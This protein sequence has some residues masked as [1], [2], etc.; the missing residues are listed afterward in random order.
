MHVPLL[1]WHPAEEREHDVDPK[2]LRPASRQAHQ[3]CAGQ[4]VSGGWAGWGAWGGGH[5]KEGGAGCKHVFVFT[6]VKGGP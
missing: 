2:V 1:T 4:E 3:Q 6:V 5:G